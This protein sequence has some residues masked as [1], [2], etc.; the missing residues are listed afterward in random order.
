M[1][2]D[3]TAMMFSLHVSQCDERASEKNGNGVNPRLALSFQSLL[4]VCKATRLA[5]RGMLVKTS[6]LGSLI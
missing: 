4:Q 1:A 2:A 5:I 6:A 3:D